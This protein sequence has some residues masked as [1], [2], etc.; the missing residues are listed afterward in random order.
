MDH[1]VL[2]AA[3]PVAPIKVPLLSPLLPYTP[4][5]PA[6]FRNYGRAQGYRVEDRLDQSHSPREL[7]RLVQS[8]LYFGL[9]SE[10]LGQVVGPDTL[11]ASSGAHS[12]QR[13]F[14]CSSGLLGLLDEKQK[15][16]RGL[17]VA[18]CH[19]ALSRMK[20]TIDHAVEA[21]VA[22][23]HFVVSGSDGQYRVVM[24]SVKLLLVVLMQFYN[25]LGPEV[26]FSY[27]DPRLFVLSSSSH[28]RSAAASFVLG[29]MEDAKICP[30]AAE[31]ICS[32]YNY[33]TAYYLLHLPRSRKVD[34]VGCSQLICKAYT[35]DEETYTTVHT[36]EGCECEHLTVDV[37]KLNSII[38]K[39]DVPLVRIKIGGKDD[40]KLALK[41]GTPHDT[42]VAMSHVWMDGL[43]NPRSNSL[44][45]CQL[46]RLNGLTQSRLT[47]WS[48]WIW[49][50]TL[51][52]P[53]PTDSRNKQMRQKA[54]MGMASI[55]QDAAVVLVLDAEI[56]ENARPAS[57]REFIAYILCSV[58]NSRCWTYQE[59]VLGKKLLYET[60]NGRKRPHVDD[61]DFF[62]QMVDQQRFTTGQ[63]RLRWF[64]WRLADAP[65][66][67]L[68]AAVG[69]VYPL[70][71]VSSLYQ[72]SYRLACGPQ[73]WR[74]LHKQLLPV[75]QPGKSIR[76]RLQKSML[77]LAWLCL[78]LLLVAFSLPSSFL[79]LVIYWTF[80]LTIT[81][82]YSCIW[83][84][85]G[86]QPMP[87]HLLLKQEM[88][89]QLATDLVAE[90]RP[91]AVDSGLRSLAPE[92]AADLRCQRLT[93][94][95]NALAQRTATKSRDLPI[96]LGGL[97]N[98]PASQ[99]AGLSAVERLRAILTSH[100]KLPLAL[101]FKEGWVR[102]ESCDF[103]DS[104]AWLSSTFDSL[105]PEDSEAPCVHLDGTS[106]TICS[107]DL[108]NHILL[109]AAV[110]QNDLKNDV[111]TIPAAAK[112]GCSE[113]VR[114]RKIELRPEDL[115]SADF[116]FL[117][118]LSRSEEPDLN[119]AL[120]LK[121][122]GR[123]GNSVDC[124]IEAC[125][126]V[127]MRSA[128]IQRIR[129]EAAP[130]SSLPAMNFHLPICESSLHVRKRKPKVMQN[131][132]Y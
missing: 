103:A 13:D 29:C 58:W 11:S 74:L 84:Y 34:H 15:Q 61:I 117:V 55:Y 26:T 69:F 8:W 12:V 130:S 124:S 50:D 30:Q 86:L 101:L 121:V 93:H 113:E 42:Y 98:F 68:V 28:R 72:T 85:E 36:T 115:D 45:R 21:S 83:L 105:R 67:Y 109:T 57:G 88:R 81:L 56:E 129:E 119:N 73:A 102:A 70:M 27:R 90:L 116:C 89:L 5:S 97:T 49:I 91:T 14:V 3:S 37:E 22:Y 107:S 96:I 114:L 128:T 106:L 17:G 99:L 18:A 82:L 10:I 47:G 127:N 32:S 66:Q 24:L 75:T 63:S 64:L 92:L 19:Q 77:A 65:M 108:N 43:G 53:I 62:Y 46:I 100:A 120:K 33:L 44:P 48:N 118:D 78:A 111:A 110:D 122:L 60:Q 76:M 79:L 126:R 35:V 40:V 39:G 87:T 54:I 41:S 23:D 131:T 25:G 94:A 52:V 2:P 125:A 59:A 80:L 95:W 16:L 20:A 9:L 104:D 4:S 1:I 6:D 132:I 38:A 7:A 71:P 123:R 112:D 31:R 51:C